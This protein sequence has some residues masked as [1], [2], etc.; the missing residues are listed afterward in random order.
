[1]RL[2]AVIALLLVIPSF[3]Q[4]QNVGKCGW[5]SRLFDGEKGI[6]P[7]VLA[8]TT[9]GTSGNQTF[10]ISSGT[11]GCTQ[12]GVVRSSWKTALFIDSNMNRLALD[13]SRGEG[14]ALRSLVALL[15]V[16]DGEK[17]LILATLKEN[18]ARIYSAQDITSQ[19]VASNIR[20]VLAENSD[21]KKY[22]AFV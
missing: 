21:L 14:E 6:A 16:E 8:V 1:M 15:G 11:S 22:S 17:E 10:A 2:V 18:F 5:G 12:S 19:Q 3:V 4:A 20:S 9:N 13:M 7:Q